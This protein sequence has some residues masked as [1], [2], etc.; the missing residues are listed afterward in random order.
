MV[1][2]RQATQFNCEH[3]IMTGC[4][5]NSEQV[6]HMDRDMFIQIKESLEAI[7]VLKTHTKNT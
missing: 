2:G 5:L 7:S 4:I 1:K 6:V 3:A